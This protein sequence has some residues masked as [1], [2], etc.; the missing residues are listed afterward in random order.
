MISII[1]RSC[2]FFALLLICFFADPT[3]TQA[4]PALRFGPPQTSAPGR[5]QPAYMPGAQ[6]SAY[7]SPP[8]A[9]SPPPAYYSRGEMLPSVRNPRQSD[10]MATDQ[11]TLLQYRRMY[12]NGTTPNAHELIGQWNGVNKGIVQV[13]GYGQFIKDI[14]VVNNGQIYGDNIQVSQV[15]PGL[16]RF[17]GWQ[18]RYDLATKDYERRGKFHVQTPTG[19][20]FFGRGSTFS[21]R[22]GGNAPNDPARLLLDQVVRIDEHHMLGRAVAK[23]GPFEIPL[24]Y[25]V[26]ERHQGQ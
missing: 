10:V 21:Y 17:N 3:G 26:L 12:R 4:Q 5:L 2:S 6:S 13:A 11:H 14:Q 8:P 16:V 25:F 19:R 15:N 23:F 1:A 18:P 24:A 20:G 22:D 9:V 7:Y